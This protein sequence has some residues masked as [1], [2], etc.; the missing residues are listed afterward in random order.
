LQYFFSFFSFGNDALK[1]LQQVVEGSVAAKIPRSEGSS[2]ETTAAIRESVRATLSPISPPGSVRGSPKPSGEFSRSSF[3]QGRRSGD[4]TRENLKLYSAKTAPEKHSKEYGRTKHSHQRMLSGESLPT[5]VSFGESSEAT[6][7]FSDDE[8]SQSAS[9][10]LRR[11]DVFRSP[12]MKKFRDRPSAE[13]EGLH[14]RNTSPG[15]TI[16]IQPPTRTHTHDSR[17]PASPGDSDSEQI[18]D[19]VSKSASRLQEIVKTGGYP[20]QRAAGWADW[21]KRRSKKMGTLLASQ[22]MGYLEKVSDMWTG[23][24]RHYKEPMGMMPDEKVVDGSEDEDE[25]PDAIEHGERFR[26]RF[27]LPETERLTAVYFGYLHRVLPLYGKIYLSNRN[28]CF[29]SM[30][31][32]TKTKMI[33]PLKDIE[34]VDKEKG[35]RFG[36]SGLVIVIRG[37]EEIFFEFGQ[38]DTRDDCCI[39]LLR[40][41]ENIRHLAESGFLTQ[42]ERQGAEAA[43][44]EHQVLQDARKDDGMGHDIQLPTNCEESGISEAPP[45]VFD[46]PHGSILN[47]KPTEPMTI[48]CLTIGSRGDV[49][50][51]IALC[52]GLMKDGH[53]TRI[54]THAEFKDWVESYGIEFR[55]VEGDPAELMQLCVEYG[56]F[57]VE[58]LKVTTSRVRKIPP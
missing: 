6:R 14:R 24:K 57:T 51:Y 53:R 27:A 15:A 34:N 12:T 52:L 7:V 13:Q 2:V 9:S 18:G 31:P 50:P 16:R 38:A 8:D 48:T 3:E 37:H 29:R 36:Y 1:V 20:L 33:L 45:I 5:D 42:E 4:L 47:F 41:I 32:G 21:M 22:P 19:S 49:Q 26:T 56:M 43:K 25:D 35:F 30:V 46:D 39:T 11:S 44:K 10:I 54:A 17:H 40:S 55:P 23:G 58:F 28:F